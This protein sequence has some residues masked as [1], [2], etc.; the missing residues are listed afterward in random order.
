MARQI[1]GRNL[2]FSE[3]W[4]V[5]QQR[6]AHKTSLLKRIHILLLLVRIEYQGTRTELLVGAQTTQRIPPT[7]AEGPRKAC[8]KACDHRKLKTIG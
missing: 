4:P 8:Q 6:G 1:L 5:L 2:G 3:T 7:R